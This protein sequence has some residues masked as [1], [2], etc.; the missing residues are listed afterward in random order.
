LRSIKIIPKSFCRSLEIFFTDIDDT[1]TTNGIITKE[2]FSAIW[3]LYTNGISVIP[4]TGRP[5]GWCDHIARMWPVK[6]VIGENGAFYFIYDREK[7]K[8]E[9]RY[10]LSENEMLN[11]KKRLERIKKRV[12]NE[13]PNCGISCDQSYRI[14]D[15]AIDYREDVSPV[16]KEEVNEICKILDEENATY[17]I[18]SIHINCWFGEFDK[19]K[20]VNVFLKDI[21]NKDLSMMK[22]K[23]IFIGDSPNDEPMFREIKNSIAV[24]NIKDFLNDLSFFPH[25]ITTKKSSLGFREAVDEILKKRNS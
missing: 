15:L 8:M 16:K 14:A 1:I 22:N 20:G 11:N 4:V 25:Y 21:Y 23:V 3:D 13:V 24:S 6:G 17:K 12:L 18:S 19:L 5:A 2:S 7:R 10:F 9:R